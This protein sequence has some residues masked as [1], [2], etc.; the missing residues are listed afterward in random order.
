LPI[1]LRRRTDNFIFKSESPLDEGPSPSSHS[2]L[3]VP[4]GL[5]SNLQRP[6]NSRSE[7]RRFVRDIRRR[8]QRSRTRSDLARNCFAE[9][10]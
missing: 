3:C 4:V 2:H 5:H 1:Y 10:R 6:R 8:D 7:Y 9:Q